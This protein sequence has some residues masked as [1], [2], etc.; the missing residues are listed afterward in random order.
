MVDFFFSLDLEE[1]GFSLCLSLT[2]TLA[3]TLTHTNTAS[4]KQTHAHL[5]LSL[6]FLSHTLADLGASEERFK[7]GTKQIQKNFSRPFF[8][9]SKA[10]SP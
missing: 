8:V 2:Y 6:S 4:L 10:T 9:S 3:R 7:N 1:V 5:S